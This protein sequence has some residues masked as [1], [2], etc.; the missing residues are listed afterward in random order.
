[1]VALSP[2][3]ALLLALAAPAA[4]ATTPVQ[5]WPIDAAQ[6][7]VQFKVRKFWFA[8]ARGTFPGLGGHARRIDTHIGADLIEVDATLDV[9]R[10]VMD[11]ARDRTHALGPGFFDAANYPTIRFTSGPFPFAELRSGGELH[12]LLELHGQRHPASLKL[13]PSDCPRQPLACV[14]RLEGTISRSAY[15]M[16]AWRGV[17]S[18]KVELDLRIRLAQPA[19]D[20]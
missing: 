6:S 9:D 1:M 8:H 13:L 11:D 12:G 4:V 15:G 14:I 19:V 7:Q 2:A 17:L 3:F 18:D 20:D 16:R 5:D 10:L